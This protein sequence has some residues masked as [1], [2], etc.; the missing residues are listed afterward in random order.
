LQAASKIVE[1]FAAEWFS[2]ANYQGGIT[3]RKAAGFI[4]H[5]MTKLGRS[6]KRERRVAKPN[7]IILCGG[8]PAPRGVSPDS[9]CPAR[10]GGDEP[11]V[12]LRLPTSAPAIQRCADVLIDLIEIASYV[13]CAD[14]AVTR[15]GEGVLAFG[16][17]WRRNFNFHIPVR[18]PSMWSSPTV[19]DVLQKTLAILS[20]DTYEFHFARRVNGRAHAT[21]FE[22]RRRRL[23]HRRA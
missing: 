17:H 13:Y 18:L 23:L 16:A 8:A 3:P 7:H 22:T 9:S 10:L 20:E 12:D 14:Q 4:S 6:F 15:G 21:V 19:L 1:Q 5:A 11:N 2:K